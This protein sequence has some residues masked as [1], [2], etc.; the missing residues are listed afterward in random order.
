MFS[1]DG[2][3][4]YV[5]ARYRNPGNYIG[6]F[7]NNVKPL[8]DSSVVGVGPAVDDGHGSH[9]GMGGHD[10]SDGG[11]TLEVTQEISVELSFDAAGQL[12]NVT[13]VT[14]T[15]GKYKL[16]WPSDISES[17]RLI[18]SSTFMKAFIINSF[19]YGNWMHLMRS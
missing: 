1:D 14:T 10:D 19:Y 2:T 17:D 13:T 3:Q 15:M 8:I 11:M 6:R 12:T 5:V 9:G 7:A 18:L 4:I 16:R